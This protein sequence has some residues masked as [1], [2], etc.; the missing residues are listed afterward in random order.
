MA[1]W[2][3]K[4]P[5]CPN[6]WNFI[7]P[8]A[9]IGLHR[10]HRK[11]CY[12]LQYIANSSTIL[13]LCNSGY[14]RHQR[15]CLE[16]MFAQYIMGKMSTWKNRHKIAFSL[17]VNIGLYAMHT[18]ENVIYNNWITSPSDWSHELFHSVVFIMRSHCLCVN[19]IATIIQ[20]S[21][22]NFFPMMHR[23]NWGNACIVNC[24]NWTSIMFN[25]RMCHH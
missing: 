20:L 6:F 8:I 21:F 25:I 7:D 24:S 9:R 18:P 17:H 12:F 5:F 16:V 13:N 2:T 14:V 1:E 22:V 19:L 4:A 23:E 11:C 15:G 10:A 3:R